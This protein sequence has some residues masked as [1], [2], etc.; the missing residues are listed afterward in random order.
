MLSWLLKK[1]I[2]IPE[3]PDLSSSRTPG[4]R[5]SEGKMTLASTLIAA[6]LALLAIWFPD[7]P[8]EE[9]RE[10][11]LWIAGL[12]GTISTAAYTAS[13]A[14]IKREMEKT[15]RSHMRRNAST[16]LPPRAEA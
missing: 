11:L 14:A 16:S 12:L 15:D 6:V 13:R 3:A 10:V 1:L 8:R 7:L 2:G 9:L 5:T 4:L